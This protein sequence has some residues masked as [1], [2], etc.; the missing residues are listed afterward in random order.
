MLH[1]FDTLAVTGVRGRGGREYESEIAAQ[2]CSRLMLWRE[3]SKRKV[4][5]EE[6]Y[7]IVAASMRAGGVFGKKHSPH[8]LTKRIVRFEQAKVT[9]EQKNRMRVREK[10][11][12]EVTK[13][14]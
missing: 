1:Q 13:G 3:R 10:V 14:E 12:K 4:S 9:N 5:K 7:R 6:V 8:T 11:W 2:L